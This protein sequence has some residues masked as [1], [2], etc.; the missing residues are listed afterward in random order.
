MGFLIVLEVCRRKR[1]SSIIPSHIVPNRLIPVIRCII[2]R[3][4]PKIY[5]I[6]GLKTATNCTCDVIKL[7]IQ[8][9]KPHHG[10]IKCGY[11]SR[12]KTRLSKCN[13]HADSTL[14]LRGCP[15]EKILRSLAKRW[16]S[17]TSEKKSLMSI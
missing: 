9:H 8:F 5:R 2:L 3:H 6:M 7:D 1:I 4:M 11:V 13:A 10:A 12:A 17:Q 14:S 16:S 15:Y